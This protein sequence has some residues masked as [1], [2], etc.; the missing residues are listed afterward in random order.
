MAMTRCVCLVALMFGVS[1]AFVTPG[2]PANQAA[3]YA[4][5]VAA[6][7]PDADVAVE[8]P[9][10]EEFGSWARQCLAAGAVL[11]LALGLAT[12]PANAEE[13]KIDNKTGRNLVK[14]NNR[15]ANRPYGFLKEDATIS[16]SPEI[17]SKLAAKLGSMEKYNARLFDQKKEDT[18]WSQAMK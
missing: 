8:A 5:S 15:V 2:V 3:S 1:H 13:A 14:G 11:G 6:A 9:V 10:S 17:E 16:T 18:M 7:R 4:A 12:A